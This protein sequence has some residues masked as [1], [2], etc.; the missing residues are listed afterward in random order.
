MLSI[1]LVKEPVVFLLIAFFPDVFKWPL[2][3]VSLANSLLR[4][5]WLCS[6]ESPDAGGTNTF[7]CVYLEC[8]AN[9]RSAHTENRQGAVVHVDAGVHPHSHAG[10]G[11]AL[12]ITPFKCILCFTLSH[13]YSHMSCADGIYNSCVLHTSFELLKKDCL[14]TFP[15]IMPH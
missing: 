5:S 2:L 8:A 6:F 9:N 1:K 12:P 13:T 14:E 7:C 4:W 10:S 11:A 15:P 3:R